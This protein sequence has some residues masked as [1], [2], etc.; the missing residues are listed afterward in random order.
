MG[1]AGGMAAAAGA[2]PAS[3]PSLSGATGPAGTVSVL[4]VRS[5]IYT[6]A[7]D[8][9]NVVLQTGADGAILVDTGPVAGTQHPDPLG[10]AYHRGRLRISTFRAYLT[11]GTSQ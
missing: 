1:A 2:P 7:G 11:G 10:P 8:G 6:R 3:A 9:I 4:P 5:G